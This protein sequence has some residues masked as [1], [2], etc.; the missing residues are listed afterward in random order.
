MSERTGVLLVGTA[1]VGFFVLFFAG[2][3]YV[4]HR[5][6]ALLEHRVSF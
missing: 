5:Q 6:P 2:A 1:I 4:E 3:A